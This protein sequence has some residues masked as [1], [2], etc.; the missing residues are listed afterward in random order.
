MSCDGLVVS[1]EMLRCV[2]ECIAFA[3]GERAPELGGSNGALQGSAGLLPPARTRTCFPP[4]NI[5]G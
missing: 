2:V 1:F 5:I 4:L 3:S